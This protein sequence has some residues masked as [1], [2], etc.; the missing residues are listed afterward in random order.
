M[1]HTLSILIGLTMLLST[2]GIPQGVFGH[3]KNFAVFSVSS[4]V[5]LIALLFTTVSKK[6]PVNMRENAIYFIFLLLYLIDFKHPDSLWGLGALY[7]LLLFVIIRSVKKNNYT[8]L[9]ICCA[10]AASWLAGWGYLQYIGWIPSN[11]SY[12]VVTG[13]YHNPAIWA[14]MVAL[15][16]GIIINAIIGFYS[17]IKRN[18]YFWGSLYVVVLFCIPILILSSARAAYIALMASVAYSLYFKVFIQKSLAKRLFGILSV[19]LMISMSIAALYVLRPESVKGR[20]LIWKVSCR[21]IQDKPLSG[22]GKGGFAANYLYYQA[23]YMK[24]SASPEEKML[25]G[26]THLSFNEPLRI[27]VEHGILGVG[28]Y[29]AF[30]IRLLFFRPTQNKINIISRSLLAGITVWGLFAYPNQTFPILLLWTLGIAYGIDLKAY[31]R[32]TS[33]NTRRN[34]IL[35]SVTIC[36]IALI[37]GGKLYRKWNAYNGLQTYLVTHKEKIFSRQARLPAEISKEMTDDAGFIY[38]RCRKER[39]A[40][41]DTGFLHSLH[42]L[43]NHFPTPNIWMMEGDYWREK[44]KWKEAEAAY[45]LAANMVPSL[46]KP[47][48]KLA[49]LYKDMGRHEEAT[50]IVHKIL[51]EKV[52]VYSFETFLL[53]REL[54]RIFED[55]FK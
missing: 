27:A 25:A 13:P 45:R 12:F 20:L 15:L 1:S 47:R 46:Q 5:L 36:C 50:A 29:I 23:A 51:T 40:K 55:S 24:S 49:I 54:K 43:E 14:A 7:L 6:I 31:P 2:M 39:T 22:F 3:P 19:L 53:H 28:A 11:S 16:S 33:P 30:I 26:N 9:L 18:P 17:S 44:G 37:A 52:K 38:L 4:T 8:V 35:L 32:Y 48:G 10:C 42:F 34:S 41:S 21:M